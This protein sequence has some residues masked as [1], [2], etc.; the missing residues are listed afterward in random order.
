MQ[1][2]QS[3]AASSTLAV[4]E[5]QQSVVGSPAT[6]VSHNKQGCNLLDRRRMKGHRWSSTKLHV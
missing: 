5:A 2:G 3:D 4:K 1:N 6:G